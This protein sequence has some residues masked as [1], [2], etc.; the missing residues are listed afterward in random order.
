[1]KRST[2]AQSG[3]PWKRS[4]L[5]MAIGAALCTPMTAMAVEF[6]LKDGEVTGSLDTTVSYGALW[7]VTGR[8]KENVALANGGSKSSANYDDGNLNYDRGDLVSSLFKM[9]NDLDLN[10]KNFGAF[11]RV[12]SF[13]DNAIQNKDFR[14]VQS[15]AGLGMPQANYDRGDER[16]LRNRLGHDYEI[17]DAY[18]RGK[19]EIA[20]KKLDARLGKQVVSWGES[21]FIPNGINI[22]NPVDVAKIRAPGAELKE[23]F[24]PV[25]MIWLSQEINENISVEAF[26]QF[27][28][29]KT[30]LDPAGSYFSTNDFISPGGKQVIAGSGRA[31]EGNATKV[32]AFIPRDPD[33]D[34]KNSGQFGFAGRFFVPTLNNTEF[35]LYFAQYHSRTPQI[36][37]TALAPSAPGTA[38]G[39]RYNT[40]YQEKI[41]MYGFSFNTAAPLGIALQGEYSYRPNQ[42]VQ[43]A[44]TDLLVE[45]LSAG[46]APTAVDVQPLGNPLDCGT[47]AQV[48]AF[49]PNAK[50]KGYKEIKYH[51]IQLT[52]TKSFGPQIG[53]DQVVAVGEAG[54]VHQRLDGFAYNGN[55]VDFGVSPTAAGALVTTQQNGGLATRNSY[56]YRAVVRADYSNAIGPINLSPRIAIAHDLRGTS[57]TFAQGVKA[58]SI[59]LSA[60]Y[61]QKWQADIAYTNFFGGE[62]FS[63]FTAANTT[64]LN[65]PT[66]P[67]NPRFP[68]KSTNNPLSDRDFIA[69]T[70]SYAF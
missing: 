25:N 11:L 18:V 65:T 53:A 45:L 8:D 54:Y 26:N 33:D 7:R 69:A 70:V 21:T 40:T 20:G 57:Q 4:I 50:A 61:Q 1:M 59:G 36:S 32:G 38:N 29:K 10:Y 30:R 47:P 23:A 48:N 37:G 62:S 9:T 6:E 52:G 3:S 22:I 28:Y 15:A 19:F 58:A 68:V 17:L 64:N 24:L 60:N 27:E 13:Y 43:M 35:A 49:G 66:P 46:C 55:G 12:T 31:N 41:R 34:P 51:Q 14:S 39:A 2:T 67:A 63:G 56:G 5:S 44:A 16:V 42:P